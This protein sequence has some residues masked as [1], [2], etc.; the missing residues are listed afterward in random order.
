MA[1]SMQHSMRPSKPEPHRQAGCR[2]SC[3]G[4]PSPY[5]VYHRAY[6][7][8][9]ILSPKGKKGSILCSL[10]PL[11]LSLPPPV[12]STLTALVGMMTRVCNQRCPLQG[13]QERHYRKGQMPDPDKR[14]WALSQ[15]DW[16]DLCD[17]E[18]A[19]YLSAKGLNTCKPER[20]RPAQ[21]VF[22]R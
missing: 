21:E 7:S 16:N 10:L 14:E 3:G 17:A 15:E 11:L 1:S 19:V 6:H 8:V 12:L 18:S 5:L 2:C 13:R 9:N 4:T 22:G 20:P